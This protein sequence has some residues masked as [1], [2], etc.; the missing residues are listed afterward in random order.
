MTLLTFFS[1]IES[2]SSFSPHPGASDATTM[3]HNAI[4]T[5]LSSS[6][7]SQPPPSASSSAM[8]VAVIG[9]GAAGLATARTL[10]KYG[11]TTTILE[12]DSSLGGVWS[13]HPHSDNRPMYRGLRTN[14][15]RELMQYR[16]LPWGGDGKTRS[17]VTHNDVKDYLKRYAKEMNVENLIKFN[18][19]V[20]HLQVLHDEDD[21]DDDDESWPK[22]KLQWEQQQQETSTESILKEETF[23]AVCICNGHYASPATPPIPGI[24]HYKGQTIH[25]IQY[26]DPSSSI[27]QDSTVLC[28]GGRASGADL[29]REISQYASHVYLSDTTCPELTNGKP[30]TEGNVSWVPKTT[31]VNEDGTISFGPTCTICPEVDIIVYCSGYDY[32]F[33]FINDESNMDVSFIEGERRVKPLYEHLWH[34]A[35][36]SLAF[37]GLQHS[38]VPFPFF[39]LQAEAIARQLVDHHSDSGSGSG[40]THENDEKK[41]GEQKDEDYL[42]IPPRAERMESAAKD[43]ERGGPKSTRVQDTHFLG[44]HQWEMCRTYAKYGGILTPTLEQYLNTNRAIYDDSKDRRMNGFP[45]GFDAY[46]YS[47]YVR[48]DENE[49]FLVVSLV[50]DMEV[51]MEKQRQMQ[52]MKMQMQEQS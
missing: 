27:F 22:I 12:K 2:A 28:I 3:S 17:Y 5:A 52:E 48:D 15:P 23:D 37:V 26:D 13:Y 30:I 6:L 49:S 32:Q 39:E 29:A 8:K 9:A 45:G 41:E 19:A 46:R 11:I 20:R 40:S 38:V 35:C 33:S 25:S 47:S 21:T 36:P 10:T 4:R 50:E 1:T 24:E 42:S 31:A 7:S 51:E 34:A 14:L 18:C 16:E 44:S 43:A